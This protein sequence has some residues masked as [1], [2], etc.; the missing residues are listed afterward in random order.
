MINTT[1]RSCYNLLPSHS[2]PLSILRSHFNPHLAHH[3]NKILP[4]TE[5]RLEKQ[6]KRQK[7]SPTKAISKFKQ[8]GWR[9][10]R[11]SERVERRKKMA[12]FCQKYPLEQ[13]HIFPSHFF[14]FFSG[15]PL[16]TYRRNVALAASLQR[17]RFLITP[18]R[19]FN[20][21]VVLLYAGGK[22]GD[23]YDL[24]STCSACLPSIMCANIICPL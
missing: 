4:V 15:S 16:R 11:L 20:G 7:S 21:S 2:S 3:S 1:R 23:L 17:N 5:K 10:D 24:G 9:K 8:E 12:D 13:S 14:A 6:E 18:R 19:E 22:R